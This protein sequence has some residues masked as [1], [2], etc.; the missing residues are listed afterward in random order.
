MSNPEKTAPVPE[1][2]LL[3]RLVTENQQIDQYIQLLNSQQITDAQQ[4]Q[5]NSS[6][7]DTLTTVYKYMFIL[8]FIIVLVLCYVLFFKNKTYSRNIKIGIVLL[9]VAFPFFIYPLEK[10]MWEFCV[11]LYRL[12]V[13]TP[14]G[15]HPIDVVKKDRGDIF[16]TN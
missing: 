7:N 8:Y 2:V 5:Y 11:F 16:V 14:V 6:H 4:F 9:F 13:K 1:E 15:D 3:Q 12:V 10:K